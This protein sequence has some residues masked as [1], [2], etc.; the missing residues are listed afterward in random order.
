MILRYKIEALIQG[1]ILA[2]GETIFQNTTENIM[3][4]A[5][6][7]EFTKTTA[8]ERL[9]NGQPGVVFT[10]KIICDYQR[11]VKIHI[12][13]NVQMITANSVISKIPIKTI[14]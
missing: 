2:R 11:P 7:W 13:F 3:A 9:R 8:S 1:K 6:M 5:K 12:D 4:K 14:V 10:H